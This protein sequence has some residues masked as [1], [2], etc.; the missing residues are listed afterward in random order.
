MAKGRKYTDQ[1]PVVLTEAQ[2]QIVKNV[3]ER[4]N[5]DKAPIMRRGFNILVG[6]GPDDELLP[7]D[8]IE[9]ATERLTTIMRTNQ[10]GTS[11]F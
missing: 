1:F 11:A 10:E 2:G 9:A 6:L 4:L 7:G 5:V 8:T 3:V